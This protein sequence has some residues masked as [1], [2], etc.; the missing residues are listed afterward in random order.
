MLFQ[1]CTRMSCLL[2]VSGL[3]LLAISALAPQ[4]LPVLLNKLLLVT[5]SAWLG[6]WLHVS[7][8]PYARPGHMLFLIDHLNPKA[9]PPTEWDLMMGRLAANAM[10]SRS[11]IMAAAMVA[12]ALG[13]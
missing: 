4:Q 12:L 9:A 7:A 3:L 10:I 6:Y 8:F 1:R 11:V 2:V 5:L 13:I